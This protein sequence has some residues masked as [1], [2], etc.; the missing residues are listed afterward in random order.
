VNVPTSRAVAFRAMGCAMGVALEAAP[1]AHAHRVLAAVPRWF[2]AWERRLTRFDAA[3]ELSRLNAA[4]GRPLRA[5]AT[6]REAISAALA[7]A[8][9]TDGLVTP[10]LLGALE[11][12]G[13]DRTFELVGDGGAAP[14]PARAAKEEWRRIAVD[15]RAGTV[16]VPAGVRVEL[17]GTAKG[18]AADR[19][20]RRLGE[21][22]PALVDAGGDVAVSGPRADGAPWPVAVADPTREGATLLVLLVERGG[23][24]TSGRDYRRWRR[25]G[26]WQHHVID[27]RTGR[28]AETDVLSV[29][30]LGPSARVAEAAAKAVLVLGS[31]AGLAWVEARRELAAVIVR[32]DGGVVESRSVLQHAA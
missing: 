32:D 30:I 12:A 31:R 1:S 2:R 28:P 21:L 26:A 4:A 19:A 29:T 15:E 24:V 6:L 14:S 8:R 11:A 3:S 27:P 20:A 22:G 23:V 16:A 10:T 7:A 25:G 9:E 18:W 5:S 17:G 13:Y